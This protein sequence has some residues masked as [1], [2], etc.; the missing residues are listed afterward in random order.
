VEK[1]LVKKLAESPNINPKKK[2][3]VKSKD[4]LE[5]IKDLFSK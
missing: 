2:D 4:F 5:R 3:G 1:D